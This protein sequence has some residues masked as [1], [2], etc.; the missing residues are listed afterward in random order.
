MTCGDTGK[1]RRGT[2]KSCSL[3]FADDLAALLDALDIEQAVVGGV[4]MGGRIAM[5]PYVY[6]P[7]AEAHALHAL[8]PH[9][10]LT[11]VEGAGHLPG[12]EDGRSGPMDGASI[13]P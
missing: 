5:A 4:S 12:L 6:T 9:S 11:V 7:V 1:A 10:V 3:D 8:V 13:G 2:G